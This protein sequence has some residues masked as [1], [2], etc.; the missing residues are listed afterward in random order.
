VA[1]LEDRPAQADLP[2][3]SLV[4]AL[5]P[6][7]RRAGRTYLHLAVP[8]VLTL[9]AAATLAGAAPERED[10]VSAQPIPPECPAAVESLQITVVVDNVPG[11]EDLG[12]AWGL[13]MLVQ[14]GEATVLFDTGPDDELLLANLQRL[15]IDPQDVD[16]VLL[17]HDHGDHTGGL[18]AF[19]EVRPEVAVYLL[20]SFQEETKMTA[21]AA[22]GGVVEV[23]GPMSLF[24]GVCTMG[25]LEQGLAEQSLGIHTPHGLVVLTGCAHPGVDRI[26]ARARAMIG[27]EVLLVAGGSHQRSASRAEADAVAAALLELGVKHVAP[28]HCTG[29][30]ARQAFSEAFAERFHPSGVGAVFTLAELAQ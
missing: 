29:D 17:S 2:S 10:P 8:L 1:A 26:V 25:R 27:S 20:P 6:P 18:R 11:R 19:L 12:T 16:A 22:Q 23:A 4:R 5:P 14:A 15:G 13:S 28:S 7:M 21:R 30:T 3:E 24:P 9:V